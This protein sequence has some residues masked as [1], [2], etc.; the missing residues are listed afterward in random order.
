MK[1][2]GDKKKGRK[3]GDKCVVKR[4]RLEIASGVNEL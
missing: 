4:T 3:L 2:G 1:V